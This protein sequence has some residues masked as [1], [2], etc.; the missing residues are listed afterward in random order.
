MRPGELRHVTPCLRASPLRGCTNPAHPAGRAMAT[1]VGTRARPP[2]AWSTTPSR[3]NRSAP[4]SPAW[5]YAGSGRSG[6]RRRSG[7]SSTAADRRIAAA[8][9]GS[10]SGGCG[11]E[12]PPAG[13]ALEVVLASIVERDPGAGDEIG[14]G[15]GHEHL[16]G[17]G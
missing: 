7:T 13:H 11:E 3:A 6:S 12:L 8:R 9:D 5:A 1:P 10:P 14:D 17:A 2:P 15:A 16:V 4:A